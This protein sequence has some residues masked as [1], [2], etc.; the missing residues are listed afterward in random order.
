MINHTF[1]TIKFYSSGYPYLQ[2]YRTLNEIFSPVGNFSHGASGHYFINKFRGNCFFL[3]GTEESFFG[4]EIKK[5]NYKQKG[6][7]VKLFHP[8]EVGKT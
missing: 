6:F 1:P 4:S 8:I 3:Q 2:T 7:P 5:G